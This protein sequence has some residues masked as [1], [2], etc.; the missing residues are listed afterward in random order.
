M[1]FEKIRYKGK[2]LE[3]DVD[4]STSVAYYNHIYRTGWGIGYNRHSCMQW[5]YWCWKQARRYPLDAI[6]FLFGRLAK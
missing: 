6:K 4:D 3:L 5:G 1:S 2:E